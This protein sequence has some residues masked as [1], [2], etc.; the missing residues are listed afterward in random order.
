MVVFGLAGLLALVALGSR[1]AHPGGGSG[2]LHQREVPARVANDILTITLLLCVLS[3][4]VFFWQARVLR[5]QLLVPRRSSWL[6][7][8]LTTTGALAAVALVAYQLHVHPGVFRFGGD[9]PNQTETQPNG[10][11]GVPALPRRPAPSEPA[12][13][14]WQFAAGLTGLA[15]VAVSLYLLR[16]RR[17][18]VADGE[19]VEEELADAVDSAIDDIRFERDPRQAVIAAYARM[20]RALAAHGLG[21][22]PAEAP[23]EY[24]ARI[25]RD[26]N[27]RE[28][29]V[30]R[31]T[32]LFERAKFSTHEIDSAMRDDAVSALE[33]VRDD[34][35]PPDRVEAA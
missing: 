3:L 30:R 7:D 10:S 17:L 19:T 32:E 28:A 26:L 33:A 21:R 8:M 13:F 1:G 11:S 16:T 6:R 18:D 24:L 25:L 27:V 31:L 4:G 22:R 9:N 5:E 34:L 23:F 29:A 20:E 15:L 35:R 2:V 14:D 12:R